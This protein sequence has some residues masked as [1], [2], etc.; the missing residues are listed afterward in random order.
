MKNTHK[1]PCVRW[2]E[3]L[4]RDLLSLGILPKA[5]GGLRIFITRQSLALSA[6][7]FVPRNAAK[8]KD[9]HI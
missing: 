5:A 6:D 1:H 7:Y 2:R 4:P 9:S 3:A 8:F